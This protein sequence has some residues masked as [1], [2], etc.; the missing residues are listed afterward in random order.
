MRS[1]TAAVHLSNS[2]AGV[3]RPAQGGRKPPVQPRCKKAPL[4]VIFCESGASRYHGGG[5]GGISTRKRECSL[6]VICD[7]FRKHL[8]C[9]SLHIFTHTHTKISI[10]V[11]SNLLLFVLNLVSVL[12]TI[13]GMQMSYFLPV[14]WFKPT[15][16]VRLKHKMLFLVTKKGNFGQ[17]RT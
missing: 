5:G 11:I 2:D 7:V 17:S 15:K 1:L 10:Y 16:E 8:K 13:A 3:P 12:I 4:I 6:N 14:A 9:S